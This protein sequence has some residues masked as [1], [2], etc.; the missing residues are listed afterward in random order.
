MGNRVSKWDTRTNRLRREIE[1]SR[2]DGIREGI[3]E[4]GLRMGEIGWPEQIQREDRRRS[5]GEL[6]N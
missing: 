4:L 5:A 1:E 2:I 6:R 3:R